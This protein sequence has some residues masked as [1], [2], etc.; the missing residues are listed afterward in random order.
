VGEITNWKNLGGPD[1]RIL[2][3]SGESTTGTLEYFQQSILRGEDPYP[4]EGKANTKALL[5]EIAAK[6]AAIGYGSLASRPGTRAVAIKFGPTS[7][8]IEPT[9]EAIR[10]KRYPIT[11]PVSWAVARKHDPTVDAFCRWILSSEGQLV[12]EASGF[13]PL[14]PAERQKALAKFGT[15]TE[16]TPVA[17]GRH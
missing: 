10:A 2:L 9:E 15:P 12:V 3:Y 13:E 7:I 1:A 4:F 8:G 5:D 11:R 14:L 6:P 17:F 16:V